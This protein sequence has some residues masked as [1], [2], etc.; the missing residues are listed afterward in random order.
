METKDVVIRRSALYVLRNLTS[1]SNAFVWVSL[2]KRIY[3]KR[4][5]KDDGFKTKV[6]RISIMAYWRFLMQHQN[7]ENTWNAI[8]PANRTFRNYLK[9]FEYCLLL[10]STERVQRNGLCCLFLKFKLISLCQR[11]P[12]FLTGCER[13]LPYKWKLIVAELTTPRQYMSGCSGRGQSFF[14][15]DM[16]AWQADLYSRRGW[17]YVLPDILMTNNFANVFSFTFNYCY[18]YFEARQF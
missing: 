11:M 4:T 10:N 18:V 5:N 7:Y 12:Y 6:E 9:T 8:D 17:G 2:C 3:W 14:F 16:Y 15:E 13:L 1:H